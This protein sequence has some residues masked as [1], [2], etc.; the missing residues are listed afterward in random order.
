MII[1][2]LF[3][4]FL[5]IGIFAFG[6]G[7]GALSLIQHEVVEKNNWMSPSEFTDIVAISQMT[8]GPVGINCATYT[9]Y[10]ATLNYFGEEADILI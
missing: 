10:T 7:Y 8:P 4:V 5:K 2:K 1:L 9:G 3:L 6:G